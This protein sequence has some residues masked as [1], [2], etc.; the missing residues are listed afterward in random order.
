MKD[1]LAETPIADEVVRRISRQNSRVSLSRSEGGGGSEFQSN[2]SLAG[3]KP[4]KDAKGKPIP[5]KEPNDKEGPKGMK[6]RRGER[7]IE[8]EKAEVGNVR[9][10]VYKYY[11]ENLGYWMIFVIF[12]IQI[13][14]QGI[15]VGSNAWLGLWSDDDDLLDANGSVNTGKRNMYL[16]G[17]GAIGLAHCKSFIC[18]KF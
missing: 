7:L 4:S 2:G 1:Q 16:A 15:G 6:P 5:G 3:R 13:V 10:D 18:F 14:T 12:L 9:L 8:K 17:Y 11:L